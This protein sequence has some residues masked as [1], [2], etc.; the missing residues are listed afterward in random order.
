MKLLLA[1]AALAVMGCNGAE[2]TAETSMS[3]AYKM[4]SQSVKGGKTD[5]TVTSLQQLKIFNGD[6]MMY[7]N[8]NPADSVSSFGVGTFSSS[9]DTVTE[10]VLFNASDSNR[11]ADPA[12]FTL[13]ISKTV[14]PEMVMQG[15][16]Y[17]LTEEYETAGTAAASPLDGAWKMTGGYTIKGKDSAAMNITQYKMYGSG[18][19]I[20]GHSYTDSASIKHTGVGFGKFVM[21]GANKSKESVIASTYYQA[22]GKDFD[23]DIEMNGTDE[24]KQTITEAD[25]T[26][27]VEIYQRMKK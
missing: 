10:K 14:I 21:T 16:K 2:T 13:V 1:T 9:K 22:R 4:L 18:Y 5:T 8:V 23:I 26:K 15:E 7:A 12:N 19:F 25:G 3:G 27:E 17:A 20:F 24:Y 11:S 6:F